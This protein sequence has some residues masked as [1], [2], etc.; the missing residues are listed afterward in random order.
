MTD[1]S[2]DVSS[3]RSSI[4]P[5]IV[6]GSRLE[7]LLAP[8]LAA[9]ALLGKL[10]KLRDP[11]TNGHSLRVALYTVMFSEA[12]E[13]SP[14]AVVRA[15][16]GAFL[17]DIGKLVVPDCVLGKPGP[18]DPEE[19]RTMEKHVRYGL[20]LIMQAAELSDAVPVVSAHHE[21]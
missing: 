6:S 2:I 1:E 15:A 19:T 20:D 10:I 13:M 11:E 14:N 12:L 18:L 3:I 21:R 8:P 7:Q 4:P 16:K 5:R 9:A 17:H